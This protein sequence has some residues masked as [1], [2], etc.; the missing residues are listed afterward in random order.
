[1]YKAIP[2]TCGKIAIVDE[3]DYEFVSRFKWQLK[4]SGRNFYAQHCFW[5]DGKVNCEKMHRMIL[6]L[7]KGEFNVDHINGDGLDNRRCNLRI[8]TD[9]QN[10]S[11]A[12]KRKGCVS[13][14]KG[15]R[16]RDETKKWYAEINKDG[17][18]KHLGCFPTERQAAMAYDKAAKEIF[19]LYAKTN[20][21]MGLL[22]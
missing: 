16:W 14:Y 1:M 3:S 20:E 19:G 8:A 10:Q 6:G 18:K 9:S 4:K 12:R 11:N 2:I 17:I 13:S 7:K 15:V 22:G 5:L 21:I